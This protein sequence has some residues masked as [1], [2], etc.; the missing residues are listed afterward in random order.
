METI[1]SPG[2]DRRRLRAA[3]APH[4]LNHPHLRTAPCQEGARNPRRTPRSR[5]R[6]APFLRACPDHDRH[7][8]PSPPGL[9]GGAARLGKKFGILKPKLCR[10]LSRVIR[11][12]FGNG[13]GVFVNLKNTV[14]WGERREV[15]VATG[16]KGEAR[17]N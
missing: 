12:F 1:R 17:D 16:N 5:R 4:P 6:T 15:G 14:S 13:V 9:T 3:Q 7:K 8:P 2:P 10:D 11:P